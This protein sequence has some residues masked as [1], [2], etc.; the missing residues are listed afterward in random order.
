MYFVGHG[1][2][3]SALGI[4]TYPV[5]RIL[6]R[7][8]SIEVHGNMNIPLK[9]GEQIGVR[10]LPDDPASARIA[11]PVCLWGDTIPYVFFPFLVLLV[12]YITP[13]RLDPLIPREAKVRVGGK[14][15]IRMTLDG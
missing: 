2:L 8:D 14:S 9:P 4:S 15:F 11:T 10:Y 3:G 6:Y 5:I 1:D 12:I 7:G 13:E